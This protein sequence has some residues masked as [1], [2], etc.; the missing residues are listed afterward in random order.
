MR[1]REFTMKD[2]YNFCADEKQFMKGYRKFYKAYER[3]AKTLDLRVVPAEADSGAIGGSLSHEFLFPSG[4]GDQVLFTCR[5]C[6]Y[7]ANI[8]KAEFKRLPLNPE[9]KEKPFKI[10]DQPKWVKT[11]A[12]N[13]EHYGEPKWRYLKNVVF[14][15]KKGKV[16]VASVRGDQDVNETKLKRALEVDQLEPATDEDL[17][18][19]GTRPG[20]V[21]SWGIKG[22][23]FIG[24]LGLPMVRNYIG[25]QKEDKTDSINVNYGRDFKYQLLADIVDARDGDPCPKCDGKLKKQKA[26]E[27]GHVFKIDHFYTEPQEGFFTDKDGKQKPLWMG[28]Y[29]IGIGRSMACVVESHHDKNGIIWPETIAPYRVHLVEIPSA[30]KAVRQ[31]AKQVYDRLVKQKIEVLWDD[32]EEASA[33]EKFADADLIGCPVRLVV[34]EKLQADGKIEWKNRKGKDMA[35]F[36][37][38]Q[39]VKKLER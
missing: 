19:L 28:S 32:R 1:V 23:T 38:D 10:I 13:V 4:D 14:R 3:I 30:D 21:H 36:S 34:S 31:F 15:N 17:K 35:T 11:M 29:G 20:Y 24:D 26:F 8:E 6:D 12:D 16:F 7:A 33:G 39:V 27:W 2:A 22:V 37:F 18:K 25:G 5:K 9:E